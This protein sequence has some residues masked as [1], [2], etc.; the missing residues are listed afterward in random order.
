[1]FEYEYDELNRLIKTKIYVNGSLN[2]EI[3]D[4]F[5]DQNNI[6]ISISSCQG[7]QPN[8]S[9][10]E[11]D[12]MK[13][14]SSLYFNSE[15]LKVLQVGTNNTIESYDNDMNLTSSSS[16]Q[17]N[18]DGYPTVSIITNTIHNTVYGQSEFKYEYTYEN[19]E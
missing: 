11:Y 10:F 4:T 12:E 17:Y 16:Y 15:L 7:A 3:D 2:C 1:M 14:P 6:E 19:I 13:T 18:N 9:S 8:Q 5:N